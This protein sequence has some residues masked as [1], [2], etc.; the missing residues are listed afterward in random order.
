MGIDLMVFCYDDADIG[1]EDLGIE[2]PLEDCHLRLFTF[3]RID[4]ISFDRENPN[5]TTIGSGG[6][7]FVCNER[8]EVVK[9]KIENS[10]NFK[11]N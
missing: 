3:Y 8:Y 4:Y 11:L 2:V 9:Q 1:K 7:D 10:I 6:D 5:Y